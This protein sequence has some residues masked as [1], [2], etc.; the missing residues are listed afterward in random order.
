MTAKPAPIPAWPSVVLFADGSELGIVHD[1]DE[2][3]LDP[4]LHAR[5]YRSEDRMIDSSGAE[6]RLVLHGSR[7]AIEPTGRHY[8]HDEMRIIAEGHI[9]SM[10]AKP[11]WLAAYLSDITDANKVRATILYVSKLERAE[12]SEE[13]DDGE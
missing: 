2:W 3:N 11:E 12:A 7:H 10:G 4:A 6:Y 8:S 5:S 13:P 9:V 1:Q